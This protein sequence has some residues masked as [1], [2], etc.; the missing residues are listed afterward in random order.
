MTRENASV[1]RHSMHER[2]TKQKTKEVEVGVA[3]ESSSD[4]TSKSAYMAHT[5]SI[6]SIHKDS[7]ERFFN[8][9]SYAD[10]EHLKIF[11]TD[12]PEHKA[13]KEVNSSMSLSLL[14]SPPNQT[15]TNKME[16]QASLKPSQQTFQ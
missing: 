1:K 6:Q 3:P 13:A 7:S 5:K 15:N 2:L 12:N 9:A 16:K 4:L 11:L 14:N 10:D 8:S